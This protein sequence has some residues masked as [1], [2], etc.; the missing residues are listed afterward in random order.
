MGIPR[1]SPC[2][3]PSRDKTVSTSMKW[4]VGAL[5]VFI[6]IVER[7]EQTLL[8]LCRAACLLRELN[9]FLARTTRI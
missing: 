2:V 9:A 8:M 4:S 7:G 1:G 5:Y 3:V 6:S